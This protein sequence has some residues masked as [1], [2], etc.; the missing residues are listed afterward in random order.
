MLDIH[1]LADIAPKDVREFARY[2]QIKD[3]EVRFTDSIVAVWIPQKEIFGSEVFGKTYEYYFLLSEWQKVK[4]YSA[5]K[6][7]FDIFEES[8]IVLDE[9]GDKKT[10]E[11]KDP[12]SLGFKYPII[13]G[14]KKEASTDPVP[15][16]PS[17]GIN[18]FTLFTLQRVIYG[19][20][21]LG[22][23]KQNGVSIS[24]VSKGRIWKV[25]HGGISGILAVLKTLENM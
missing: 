9:K 3:G 22:I 15:V 11:L 7:L 13:D 14:F 2:V 24:L 18:P 19:R 16:D 20:T 21:S 6:F 17:F 1:L 25:K 8:L 23:V 4:A 10:I 12:A 5:K